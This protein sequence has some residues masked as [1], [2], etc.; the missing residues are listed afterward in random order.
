MSNLDLLPDESEG[1]GLINSDMGSEGLLEPAASFPLIT[2]TQ[3]WAM[4]DLGQSKISLHEFLRYGGKILDREDDFINRLGYVPNCGGQPVAGWYLPFSNP[5]SGKPFHGD[6]GLPYGRIRMQHPAV[7]GDGKKAKYLSRSSAGQHAF[8]LPDV[9]R[10]LLEKPDAPLILTEGEK[11]AW[12]ATIAG[13]PTIGLTGNYGWKIPGTKELLP[14]LLPY[15]CSPRLIVVV[16]DSDGKANP[17]FEASTR[18]LATALQKHGCQLRALYL[19]PGSSPA[20][21]GLDDYLRENGPEKLLALLKENA[22][23]VA[24]DRR[25]Q[26]SPENGKLGGRPSEAKEIADEVAKNWI[27]ARGRKTLAIH[28]GSYYQYSCGVYRKT[29]DADINA[30]IMESIRVIAPDKATP[31]M[32]AAVRANLESADMFHLRSAW[33]SPFFRHNGEKTPQ[34]I[35]FKNGHLDMDQA[36]ALIHAGKDVMAAFHE[37]TPDIFATTQLPYEFDSTAECPRFDRYLEEVQHDPEARGVLLKLCGLALMPDTSYN[38][39]F[40]LYGEGGCGK[41]VFLEV[42]RH[43]VGVENCCCVPLAD[44]QKQFHL[45]GLT[46]ARLNI[47]GDMPT[48]DGWSSHRSIEG[49]LK[50]ITDG[51]TIFVEEKYKQGYEARVIARSVFVTNSLPHFSDRSLAMADRMRVIPFKQRF[52]GKDQEDPHLR[53]KLIREELPGIFNRALAQLVELKK[54]TRFPETEEGR[55]IKVEH[56]DRCIIERCFI[57]ERIEKQDGAALFTE[58][59]YKAFTLY[60]RASGRTPVTLDN[61]KTELRRQ[62]PDLEEKR[63]QYRDRRAMGWSGIRLVSDV[64]DPAA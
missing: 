6:D 8:I 19:P 34:L 48:D 1:M 3:L 61:F 23:E 15:L 39:F 30:E 56:L 63:I 28:R 45:S 38:V 13:I 46:K 44:L 47:I 32:L 12:C 57:Q 4:N 53:E 33:E 11:K 37:N 9:H 7:D 14:E 26:T 52:R 10:F 40:L 31:Y 49:M 59:M 50:D 25:A 36:V 17:G 18:Q 43:L 16:W 21:V 51:G 2:K 29:G 20:K 58:D 54:L 60:C 62:Y 64:V 27:D 41:S 55:R 5:E 35:C 42:L 24:P 22:H